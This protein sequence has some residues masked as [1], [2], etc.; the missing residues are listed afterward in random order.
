M[1]EEHPVYKVESFR[2]GDIYDVIPR[3]LRRTPPWDSSVLD[4]QLRTAVIPK[5]PIGLP[6]RTAPSILA[7]IASKWML[8]KP[9][10]PAPAITQDERDHALFLWHERSVLCQAHLYN[11]VDR[12]HHVSAPLAGH[13]GSCR[14]CDYNDFWLRCVSCGALANLDQPELGQIVLA[15]W[16]PGARVE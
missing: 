1:D 10:D 12:D 13:F 7:A 11:A 8:Y 14:V 4:E 5:P 9:I 6:R 2:G 15:Q 3:A 16:Q